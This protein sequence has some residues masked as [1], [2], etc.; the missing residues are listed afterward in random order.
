MA[1]KWTKEQLAAIETTGCNLLVSAAA[2]AGKTAVLVER[3][4]R[5]LCRSDNPVDIDRMLVVTFTEAAA[6]EMRERIASALEKEISASYRL[7][8]SKQLSLLNGASI[9]TLHSFCLDVIRRYFYLLED[10]DPS[11]RVADE[12][13]AEI[14]Q[15]DVAAELLE[16]SF[17]AGNQDF[18][19]L[20]VHYGG[21]AGDDRLIDLIID[22]Y[23]YC[24]SNPWPKEWLAKAAAAYDIAKDAGEESL[25]K[26]L[27]PL[28]AEISLLLEQSLDLLSC[29]LKISRLPD[30]PLVYEQAIR[31]EISWL[32][33]LQK[34]AA[35]S[36]EDLRDAWL[37]GGFARLPAARDVDS[38][39]KERVKALRDTA[40]K[41]VNEAAG[42][43]FARSLEDFAAEIADLA[44]LVKVLVE[45]VGR[46]AE[47]YRRAKIRA[48]LLDF[49]DLE[50]Y[51]LQILLDREALPGEFLPSRAALEL[52]GQFE[53]VLVDEYQDISPVQDAI[54]QLVSRQE[55]SRPNLFMVGDVK[56]SIYRFRLAEPGLFLEKYSRFSPEPGEKNRKIH[57]KHNF[58]CRRNIVNCVNYIF[59]R[60]M[61]ADVTEIEYDSHA[62]LV[63]GANYPPAEVKT[64]A[65]EP[66][67]IVLLEKNT[68]A[69]PAPDGEDAAGEE[70]LTALE[71]EGVIVA[72]KIRQ[73]MAKKPQAPYI[74]DKDT[75]QYRPLCYRDIVILM[76]STV[77][78]ANMIAE[79]LA[80]YNIPAYADLSTGYFASTEIQIMLSLL[81]VLDNPRQDIPLAAVLRAPFSGFSIENL[82]EI[83]LAG[84]RDADLWRA[85]QKTAEAGNKE[86]SAAAGEFIARIERWR[87]IA[88]K[89]KLT[90]LI[91]TVYRETG[92]ADYVAGM[93]DGLK[94]QAN[95]KA[96]FSRARQFDRFTRQGLSRFLRFIDQLQK[97]GEDLG[98][99]RALAENEDVVRIMSI[100]KAKGLEFPVV[101]IC[102]L[103]KEFNFADQRKE[104]L[105][106]RRYGLAPLVINPE[107]KISY[108]SLPYLALRAMGE[109]EMRSEEMRILYV[110][111]TRAREKLILTG[112]VKNLPA[113]LE[114]WQETR[115]AGQK[116]LPA[117]NI[118]N[119]KTCLEW[120]MRALA[121]HPAIGGNCTD[122]KK[123]NL[124][125]IKLVA[126]T[127]KADNQFSPE[128]REDITAAVM[129]LRPLPAEAEAATREAIRDRLNYTYPWGISSVPAKLSVTEIKRRY[130]GMT[131]PEDEG[132]KMFTENIFQR[133][134][135]VS[136]GE[137]TPQERGLLY[138][139]LLQRL[140]LNLPLDEA[141]I[142][143]QI[144]NLAAAKVIDG[145][146]INLI[147]P[148]KISAFF[149]SEVG[150]IILENRDNAL[151]EWPFTIEINERELLHGE[152][153]SEREDTIIVQGIIDVL[154]R[155]PQG[156]V[157]IDYK[158]D[159]IK[160]NELAILADRYRP[161]LEYYKKAVER[162]LKEKVFAVYIYSLA[163]DKALRL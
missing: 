99:A 41:L 152:T 39:S 98:A 105:L 37:N 32:E 54:L 121:D 111:M 112:S 82:A 153:G 66:L 61:A 130:A 3:V 34:L 135:F 132:V 161:Q 43:F 155:A 40:K 27:Q 138:H 68:T 142:A 157:I 133:P 75:G 44:P 48:G 93:P 134:G 159:R 45:T 97:S 110:A 145:E 18:L 11:F 88:R 49:N 148:A 42:K 131:D 64:F 15:R 117:F 125:L 137:M 156:M 14:L 122:V 20:A 72:E 31:Q 91:A 38:N 29:A 21:R 85:L 96:L 59:S 52:A 70:D 4:I 69:A 78:R 109:A 19:T 103:G 55:G 107:A 12:A 60:L 147:S 104:F 108:P 73:L 160:E 158:T 106:H 35:G 6:A 17:A 25:K 7:A 127:E 30:G 65:D 10:A 53:H 76:R 86:L 74:L 116:R 8:L 81:Q 16:E 123:E 136:Y 90:T 24:W 83:R 139:S 9:S 5:L 33:K 144:K 151:R 47:K 23:N 92:Y 46:F 126:L 36:W 149:R 63:Y 119:A 100:H 162:I 1:V 128:K 94:R 95:L 67:E 140:D 113:A 58:R 13:E 115:P 71:R 89:E 102:D 84:G 79:I 141:G 163:I 87:D 154:V 114:K 101:F 26:W 22:L 57:L 77:N 2:G 124:P 120:L 129:N 50:H 51:C 56:Q 118:R 150:K 80:R 143:A 146:S 62:A 28:K